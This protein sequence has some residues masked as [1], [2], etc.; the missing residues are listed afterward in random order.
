LI[1][2]RL[3][4]GRWPRASKPAGPSHPAFDQPSRRLMTVGEIGASCS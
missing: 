3:A 4:D 2:E 1:D